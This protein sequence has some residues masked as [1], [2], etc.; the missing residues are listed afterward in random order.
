MAKFLNFIKTNW[1][2]CLLIVLFAGASVFYIWDTNKGK[3][4]GKSSNGEDVVYSVNDEDVTASQF[5]DSM[6]TDNGIS[7]VYYQFIKLVANQAMDTTD[8]MTEYADTQSETILSTYSSNYGTTYLTELSSDLS[9]LGYTDYNDLKDYLIQYKKMLAVSGDYAKAHFDD[10]QIRSVSYILIKPE[11]TDTTTTT[12]ETE[13]TPTADEQSRMKAVDDALASGTSFADAAASYS[14]DTSTST[15]GG[16]LGVIDKNASNID[17]S[18][19]E[20]A[21]NLKEGEV[22]DWV[23]SSSFGYFK[24]TCTAASQESLE[25]EY[26][27]ADTDPYENLVNNY[28]SGILNTA[29]WQKAVELGIDFN[30]NDEL[31][32]T[33]KTYMG[34]TDGSDSAE[35]EATAEPS[36]SA[37]AEA[38]AAAGN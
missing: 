12:A 37:S 16:K 35:T 29:L 1:F 32:T 36:A 11:E 19:L 17:A 18:F 27:D 38:S 21:L 28:D 9:S 31:E 4:Q 22:S 5:Y 6:Y 14:E 33:L 30:G 10:L 3:L 24:I 20:T 7:A 34:I 15:N 2:M 13:N 23:Y 26:V 25:A 8:A